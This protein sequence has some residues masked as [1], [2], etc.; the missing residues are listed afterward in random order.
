MK[1]TMRILSVVE[2]TNVNAV[3]KLVLDFYRS[4]SEL[5]HSRR[6][7]PRVEGSIVTFDRP[8]TGIDEPNDFIRAVRTAGIDLDVIPERRRFDLSVI[9]ALKTVAEGRRPD[10]IITN[11][12]KS[13]FLMWRS[14][15]WKKYPWVA[16]HHGY[17]STDRKMRLYNRFDRFSLPKADAVVTVC[18]A[19]A[20]ELMTVARVRADKIRVQHN[21]VRPAPP[22]AAEDVL[23]LRERWGIAN[24]Q[25]VML[26]IGRLSKEKAQ[27]DLIEAYKQLGAANPDLNCTLV[28]VGDGPERGPLEAAARAP[29]IDGRVIFAGQVKDVQPFYAVAD[30]FVLSSHSEGSPNVLL[31]AMAAQVPV[32]ATSVGGVPEMVENEKSALLVP[33]KDPAVLATAITRVLS[34]SNVGL[35]LVE[36]A[37]AVLAKNHRPEQYVEALIKIYDEAIWLRSPKPVIEGSGR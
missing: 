21:S 30:V 20:R 25:R 32:V 37:T 17:T 28:I 11:S 6:D 26:S 18:A 19:F 34:D 22:P 7:F 5:N 36:D 8:T 16:F 35:R 9:P 12:V 10:I 27:A 15:L 3:A 2:A 14:R 29:G 1:S 31:E 13:H 4:A 23:A 24:D 33:A